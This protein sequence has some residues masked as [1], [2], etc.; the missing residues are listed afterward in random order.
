VQV[1]RRLP[2]R[3]RVA[4]VGRRERL[5]RVVERP[6]AASEAR[7][8][9]PDRG[10]PQQTRQCYVWLALG[11]EL[12]IQPSHGVCLLDSHQRSRSSVRRGLSSG[13]SA[14]EQISKQ[15]ARKILMDKSLADQQLPALWSC[16]GMLLLL[17]QCCCS[18]RMLR[19]P[20]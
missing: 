20:R 14:Y 13:A 17:Q 11:L 18:V 2:A 15:R 6:A 7:R 10:A 3:W 1:G 9:A 19:R 4:T 16:A 8:A 5:L 12:L